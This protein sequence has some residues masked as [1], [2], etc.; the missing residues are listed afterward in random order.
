MKFME[1]AMCHAI[2]T[3]L[4]RGLEENG[5][6]LKRLIFNNTKNTA[7]DLMTKKK[8]PQ[9]FYTDIFEYET[10]EYWEK[11]NFGYILLNWYCEVKPKAKQEMETLL[12]KIKA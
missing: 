9:N 6:V 10:E 3:E 8:I 2:L 4:V 1:R 5:I 7:F 12:N 11:E